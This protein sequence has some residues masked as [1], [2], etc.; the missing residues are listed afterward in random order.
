MTSRRIGA[1]LRYLWASPTTFIGLVVAFALLRRGHM[2]VVN[3][4]VEAHGPLL[5]RA[6]AFTPLAGGADA[7]TLGHVVLGRNAQ[8]LEFTR[9]HERIHVRQYEC[10]G[11]FFVPAYFLA[12]AYAY[13]RNRDPYFDNRFELE[14]RLSPMA[15]SRSD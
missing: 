2:A 10:W 12:S 14:A 4:V 7:M 3:G 5:D 1:A 8:V 9:A 13:A 11:P 6:L 15:V